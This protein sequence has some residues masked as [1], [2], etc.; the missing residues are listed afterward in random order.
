MLWGDSLPAMEFTGRAGIDDE[1]HE[2][3][4]FEWRFSCN[5]EDKDGKPIGNVWGLCMVAFQT[6]LRVL[7]DS[8]IVV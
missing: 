1:V 4:Q 6:W 8:G 2:F 5:V 3:S 7:A